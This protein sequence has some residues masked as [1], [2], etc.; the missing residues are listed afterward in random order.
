MII[1]QIQDIVFPGEITSFKL[2]L[3]D[4]IIRINL[5]LWIVPEILEVIF[6]E[7]NILDSNRTKDFS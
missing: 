3:E 1:P 4:I 2:V 7:N 6:I 5:I